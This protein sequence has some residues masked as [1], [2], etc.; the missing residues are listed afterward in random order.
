MTKKK[1]HGGK[2]KGAGRKSL[3]D[4][5]FSY[6]KRIALSVLQKNGANVN[7]KGK[8]IYKEK[9]DKLVDNALSK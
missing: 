3:S 4:P 8:I 9:I 7:D 6:N 5:R 2:R 1:K